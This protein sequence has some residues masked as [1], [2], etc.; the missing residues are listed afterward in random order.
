MIQFI[1]PCFANFKKMSLIFLFLVSTNQFVNAQV[2]FSEPF[3]EPATSV[4]GNDNTGGVL[5][6]SVCPACLAGDHYEVQ[7]GVLEGQDTNGPA[8]WETG[9]IDISSCANFDISFSITSV[10]VMEACGTGCNSVDWVQLEY[11]IDGSGW[12]TPTNS[13]FC[14]GPCA[15]INVVQSDDVVGGTINYST[16]CVIGGSTLQLRIVVQTWAGAEMWR[17]DNVTVSC[18]GDPGIDAGADISICP[19]SSITLDGSGTGTPSWNNGS[20]LSSTSILNPIATPAST[21]IYTL[22]LGTG[23]CVVTDDVTVTIL[24]V[25]PILVN[26][27]E[28]IC[29]GDCA[30]L[31]VSGG[32]FFVWDPATGI[33]DSSLTN[34]NVCPLINTTYTVTSY[35]VGSNLISNGDFENGN[36]DFSSSYSFVAPFNTGEAQY[37]VIPDPENYNG[38][39]SACNDHTTGAGNMMVVNGS[40]IAGSTI[41]CQTI[42]VTPN[43]DF[44][45]SAWLQ[46]VFLTNPASLQFTINGFSIGANLN[47]S[48]TTCIWNEF[49]SVWN[50]GLSTS[51]TICI[52]NLNTNVAGN[53]FALDDISFSP[54]CE[55]TESIT[56]TVGSPVVNA[57]IDQDVCEGDAVTLIA[58]NPDGA[59]ITWS[60][61]ITDGIAFT[62]AVGS[63]N[64]TVTA[65]DLAGC[66]STDIVNVTVIDVPN[67]TVTAAGPF[68]VSD[69]IQNL[70]SSPAGG[71]WSSNCGACINS[72]TGAF[73]PATAGV[74]TWNICY[75]A[76]TIPCQVQECI[77]IIVFDGACLLT[78]SAT[79]NNPT[80]FGFTDGSMTVNVLN[81]TGTP[82]FI[83]TNDLGNVVNVGG[84]NAV[85][86]LSEGW[87]SFNVT[88]GAGCI[89]LDSVFLDD[90]NQ[91]TIN[92]DVT[93]PLCYGIQDGLAVCDTV[94]NYT[95]AYNQLSYFWNPNNTG[96]NGLGEDSLINI[97][98]GTY[99]LIINDQNG[100]SESFSFNIVYPDSLYLIQFGYEPA[101]CRVF[102]YQ[103][104]NGVV[105][106]AAS[107]GTPDY[108]YLWT[109]LQTG[110]QSNNTTW[111]GLNPGDYQINVTDDNGCVLIDVITVDSLNPIADFTLTSP[112]F[113][114]N[115]VGNAVVNVHFENQSL[116][117]SN[118]NDPNTDT[119]FFWNFGIDGTTWIISHDI[120]ETFDQTYTT[121]GIYDVCLITYNNNGCTDTMCV[122]ITIYDALLFE[123]INIFT[124][125]GDGINDEF[126]FDFR[127]QSIEIFSCTILD[128]W[129]VVMYEMTSV[130]DAWDGQDKKGHRCSDGVYFY[131][132]QY[133][134]F[135]GIEGSG[136]GTVHLV[137]GK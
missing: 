72:I 134:S 61:G 123:P 133:T 84:S 98:E 76:G 43:T 35:T 40:S 7:A 60:N 22:S 2:I 67:V 14:A 44:L 50:S 118:L 81:E 38:G 92:L 18:G 124:P 121:A 71:V 77:S 135:N 80:C 39:F 132:Y 130:V 24:N 48:G 90:P 102:Y 122:P 136:Q 115:Y 57:G 64:Y 4:L 119:T 86:N 37:N 31:T 20:T 49:F 109:N 83:I 93:Q 108:D 131:S 41:W 129:G 126:T 23:G 89:V 103:S 16:G 74:G 82:I 116:N 55:Q 29:P 47:A 26:P 104:G 120:F 127:A 25:T 21:T 79:F 19:G 128:R 17:I 105:Y 113:S 13:T 68:L 27:D 5:W 15:G 95:G 36:T 9:I 11:N 56:I 112:E 34:Q 111:G 30:N 96:V 6:S 94:L 52:T 59:V 32:D 65:T 87:Y 75:T 78:A 28:T 45:F 53:D 33:V 63:I 107:G 114:S 3:D 100:C 106:A 12:Q 91:M 73:N 85:N 54:V 117:Y 97:G 62:P 137:N 1:N 110:I 101:Y 10:D 8:T 58:T 69:G 51:A 125:D 46:S 70:V 88:D 42:A 66:S 99:N